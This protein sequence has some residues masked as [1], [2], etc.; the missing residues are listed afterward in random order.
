MLGSARRVSRRVDALWDQ[1]TS[2]PEVT[3]EIRF[4]IAPGTR[5]TKDVLESVQADLISVIQERFQVDVGQKSW[6][7]AGGYVK[8]SSGKADLE[9]QIQRDEVFRLKN[10]ADLGRL[11]ERQ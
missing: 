1:F 8:W 9:P 3:M 6:L 2:L 7:E 11:T 5:L 4:N 10:L